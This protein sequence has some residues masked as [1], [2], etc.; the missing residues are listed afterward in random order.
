MDKRELSFILEEGEG[1]FIEFKEQF[2]KS[3]AK[4]I[5]AFANS[6]GGRIFLGIS[7][8]GKIKGIEIT[9]KLKSEI[10]DLTKHCDPSV[11]I[12]MEIFDNVLIINVHEGEDKPYACSGGFYI[13]TGP[14]S[15]KLTRD[16]IIDFSISEG[17]IR[18]DEQINSEFVYPA[19]FDEIKFDQY[20]K[21]TGLTKNMEVK[22]IL[23]NL[24]VAKIINK[25]LKFNNAGILFFA[26]NP[27]KFFINSKVIC[28]NYQTNE[29]VTVIDK[30]DLNNGLISNIQEAINYVTR[31]I[32]VEFEIKTPRRKEI[33]QYPLQAYRE[34][35]VNAIMH[36]DYFQKSGH[37]MIEVFRNKI[38]I[39]N[40]GGLVKWL[41][42]E[43]FGKYSR[44]RNQIIASLLSKTEYVEEIGSGINRIKNAMKDAG[45]SEPLFEYN[46][47][48]MA[49]L[50][51]KTGGRGA[52]DKV[53]DKV[54]DNQRKILDE[55]KKDPNITSKQLAELVS[56][57][58]RKIKDNL[59]KLKQRGLIERVGPDRGGHWE[60][61]ER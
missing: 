21:I 5:V 10:Q 41:K 9:N 42:P 39:S 7:D 37:V 31:H 12:N 43:D 33:T 40:P 28:V 38:W 52:I 53:T 24:N 60:I 16:E 46:Y 34:A 59:A 25:E 27:Q 48:F 4:E 8:D 14:N 18:F 20:L 11:K 26:K 6:Q 1:Q 3:V 47:S 58:E 13:R 23:L 30:K 17:K 2:D 49:V 55:I 44:P 50:N 54:T 15:Q 51:D 57:S 61:I 45:L 29:K 35:I 36:R 22:D 56:I 32:N 19:D